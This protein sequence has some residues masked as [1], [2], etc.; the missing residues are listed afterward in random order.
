MKSMKHI[1]IPLLAMVLAISCQKGI[2]PISTVDPGPDQ[3]NPVV[4]IKYPIE[5]A[6]IRDDAPKVPIK[7]QVEA[8]DDIELASITLNLDGTNIASFTSFKDYRHGV[9][10]Y[11]YDGVENGDHVLI[12]TGTDLA[13]KATSQTV[14]FKKTTP[15]HPIY[16]GEVFYMPFDGDYV[17][18]VSN[19][20][21]TVVG[22]PTL[23]AAKL[24]L[25]SF[26][27]FLDSYLTFPSTVLQ[28][29]TEF[30]VAFWYNMDSTLVARGGLMA[31]SIPMADPTVN[32]DGDV[33]W[34]GF[35]MGREPSGKSQ[36]MFINFGTT[37]QENWA[38]PFATVKWSNTWMHIAVS[39]SAT[40]YTVY[41]NNVVKKTGSIPSPIDFTGCP[42]ISIGSGAPNWIYWTHL[43]DQGRI[44]EL[45]MFNKAISADV[46]NSLYTA[47][48]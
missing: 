7:I 28:G 44:D 29:S 10:E 1:F 48:K 17:E 3:A 16:D 9:E 32:P 6:Q 40:N 45:R 47:T 35:R 38:N 34:T 27:G 18:A 12:V 14:H 25:A 23:G 42:S 31:I 13:G 2:D 8:T 41:V 39:I 22:S 26:K 24:G 5:G 4:N 46:V 11:I 15:Y 19:T 36:N 20:P 21:A 33:R 43:S 30:S 37:T